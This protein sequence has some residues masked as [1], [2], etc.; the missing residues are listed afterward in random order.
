MVDSPVGNAEGVVE[1]NGANHN[2]TN[3]HNEA[4]TSSEPD[5]E[6]G[7][8]EVSQSDTAHN[9]GEEQYAAETNR[10]PQTRP[11]EDTPSIGASISGEEDNSGI[12]QQYT[13][14]DV[15]NLYTGTHHNV[16]YHQYTANPSVN[17]QST[18]RE[19]PKAQPANFPCV[20]QDLPF[21]G[22]ECLA[23]RVSFL[24]E[25]R[26][27]VLKPTCDSGFI[28]DAIALLLRDFKGSQYLVQKGGV[29][30]EDYVKHGKV[31]HNYVESVIKLVVNKGQ[32]E[33]LTEFF[34]TREESQLLSSQ[35]REG[36]NFL[37]VYVREN[38]PIDKLKSVV[39]QNNHSPAA[40][41]E[42]RLNQ[43]SDLQ[44]VA[45]ARELDW[46]ESLVVIVCSWL[47]GI[48]Y[49]LLGK[50]IEK[51][52]AEKLS[53]SPFLVDGDNTKFNQYQ[54]WQSLWRDHSDQV[55]AKV[56]IAL[57][58][59]DEGV[60]GLRFEESRMKAYYRNEFSQQ[61]LMHLCNSLPYIESAIFDLSTDDLEKHN[62]YLIEGFVQL[63]THLD[64]VGMFNLNSTYLQTLYDKHRFA[65]NHSAEPVNRFF[66]LVK[67][68]YFFNSATLSVVEEYLELHGKALLN[69][70]D[71]IYHLANKDLKQV[72]ALPIQMQQ[73]R[74]QAQQSEF[75]NHYFYFRDRALAL[76]FLLKEIGLSELK[77]ISLTDRF[78]RHAQNTGHGELLTFNFIVPMQ[79]ECARHPAIINDILSAVENSAANDGETYSDIVQ[80][81]K[82]LLVK[83]FKNILNSKKALPSLDLVLNWLML[84]KGYESIGRLVATETEDPL[85]PTEMML[86]AFERLAAVVIFHHQSYA[87]SG[88]RNYH[89]GDENS[90]ISLFKQE[91]TKLLNSVA[92]TVNYEQFRSAKTSWLEIGGETLDSRLTA[93]NR[94]ADREKR[95]RDRLIRK[96]NKQAYLLIKKNFVRLK[97]T[98]K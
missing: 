78:L 50:I 91:L 19:F 83:Q 21:T 79:Y 68:L 54:E 61:S 67:E 37:V 94:M 74:Y 46:L 76:L 69:Q 48:S 59:D 6:P 93:N 47:N 85:A 30:C 42:L 86:G 11:E 82:Y 43:Q 16:H 8:N 36:N 72:Y 23:E 58:P 22:L 5:A 18:H 26:W 4:T 63:L 33:A 7:N 27:I 31:F 2:Q 25:H 64:S 88:T 24:K 13:I 90:F 60:Y 87:D 65:A 98:D 55:L 84:E 17:N 75:A 15:K 53:Q 34:E 3:V 12:Q 1:S 39:T 95:L 49:Q 80:W 52:L 9:K 40:Y 57:K 10:A 20:Q 73:L 44:T 97:K 14:D 32:V 28:S 71:S 38:D 70:A 92:S 77:A 35:L 56:A 89:E 45:D 96:A 62:P 66:N 41:W 29:N 51:T 81:A